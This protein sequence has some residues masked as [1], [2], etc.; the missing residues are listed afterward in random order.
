MIRNHCYRCNVFAVLGM[1]SAG[2]FA[3]PSADAHSD[4][5]L[6]EVDGQVTIG[7][8]QELG[9]AEEAFDLTTRMFEGVM[10]PA[11]PPFAPA[12]FGRDE[13]GFH[14]LPTDSVSLPAGA[15]ALPSSAA[16]SIHF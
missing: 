4:V 14:A 7:G 3:P 2:L 13:P 11:F 10:I 15:S 6:A 5:F 8:A 12:D 9:T 1:L 16:V